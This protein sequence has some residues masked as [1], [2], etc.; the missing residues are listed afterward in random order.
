MKNHQTIG[1][2]ALSVLSGFALPGIASADLLYNQ[3]PTD[4]VTA[5][6]S[7]TTPGQPVTRTA[8]DFTISGPAG[9]TYRL[10]RFV[11]QM[12]TSIG[13][14][15]S[16]YRVE[17][18]TDAGGT[19]GALMWSR[20]G[21]SYMNDAGWTPGFNMRIQELIYNDNSVIVNANQRYWISFVGLEGVAGFASHAWG[22]TQNG[23]T[24]RYRTGDSA[25]V[26]VQNVVGE[27]R[28]FAFRIEGA[29]VAVPAPGAAA[30]LGLGAALV[31]RRRRV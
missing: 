7:A 23:L 15:P 9:G 5:L 11:G 24:G 16:R 31:G 27:Y 13:G 2:V 26:D 18:Y 17:I 4:Q 1:I 8:D 25:W 14:D 30:L 21:A 28:D 6:S 19:P 20:T 10:T 12:M 29:A 3:I 22:G